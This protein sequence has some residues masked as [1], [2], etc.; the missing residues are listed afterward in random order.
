MTVTDTTERP[1]IAAMERGK[2]LVIYSFQS[3]NAF[4]LYTGPGPGRYTLPSLTGLQGHD[5]TKKAHPSYSFGL[6]LATSC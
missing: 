5:C 1:R 6:R 3:V 2:E 4:Y